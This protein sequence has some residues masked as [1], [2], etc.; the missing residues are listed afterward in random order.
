M[1]KTTIIKKYIDF[2]R[3]DYENYMNIKTNDRTYK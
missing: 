3:N 2:Y 1:I